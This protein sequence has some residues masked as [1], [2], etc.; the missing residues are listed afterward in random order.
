MTSDRDTVA[1][2]GLGLIG[3][4][5]ARDLVS[6]GVRVAGYDVHAPTLEQAWD[7]GIVRERLDPS[8]SNL[9]GAKIVILAVPVSAAP[10]VLETAA[11]HLSET[12]LVTDVGSTKRRVIA[13]AESLSLG[14]RFVGSHPMAGDHRS[15]WYS[16]RKGLFQGATSY[17]CPTRS[18]SQEA[19]ALAR[20]L[21]TLLGGRP[22]VIDADDHDARVAFASHLPHA[23]SAAL[24]LA[25][26]RAKIDLETL[27]PG[28]RD[29]LRIAASSPDIW[30]A[31]LSE[32]SDKVLATLAALRSEL[33]GLEKALSEPDARSLHALL[34]AAQEWA[35]EKR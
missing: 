7:E 15:G 31:I 24:A 3:G 16:A 23:V 28:G 27:G 18:T 6:R 32:N 25:L 2:I 34:S 12:S 22:V 11:K 10:S 19:L 35:R 8:L 17:L 21:W 29:M 33:Q 26:S 1:I 9:D 13:A 5:I 30:T 4:S 20:E 14:E